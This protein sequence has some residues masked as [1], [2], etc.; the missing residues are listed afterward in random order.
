MTSEERLMPQLSSDRVE[1]RYNV[2]LGTA[3]LCS[4]SI[5]AKR[6]MIDASS[7]C[8]ESAASDGTVASLERVIAT[9]PRRFMAPSVPDEIHPSRRPCRIVQEIGR[10]ERM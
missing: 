4:P 5:G 1:Y 2:S 10:I 8:I 7:C 3:V 6:T 9:S